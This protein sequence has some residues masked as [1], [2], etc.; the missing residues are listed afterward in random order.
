MDNKKFIFLSI[1][2]LFLISFTMSIFV[3]L[4]SVP[5]R[6]SLINKLKGILVIDIYGPIIMGNLGRM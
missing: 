4:H 1:I 6:P 3:N 5:I 2:V